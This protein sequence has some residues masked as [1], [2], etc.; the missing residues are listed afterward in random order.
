M[1]SIEEM[2][3]QALA[4]DRH[5]I[6]RLITIMESRGES[7]RACMAVLY[8][9]TGKAHVVGITG[10]PGTGK[11]S[12]VNE[13]ARAY[14]G[15]GK[16]V[17]VVAVDP[18][19]PFTGGAVLGD[20]LRMRDVATNPAVFIRSMASRGSLGGLA[21]ATLDAV[22]VLDACGYEVILV[23]TVGA[24]QNEVD[25]A[26]MADTT[27]VVV[28][29]SAG[30][31]I[32]TMK[33]GVLE[34]ADVLVVNKADLPGA[35]VAVMALEGM[36][37]MGASPQRGH[38]SMMAVAPGGTAPAAAQS[39]WKP[40]IIKTCAI[41]GE[42]VDGI[43]GAVARHSQFTEAVGEK[44]RRDRERAKFELESDL[45]HTL[46]TALLASLP[47]TAVQDAIIRIADRRVTPQNAARDLIA[48]A[49]SAQHSRDKG[50][51]PCGCC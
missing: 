35:D 4:G 3:H 6:A 30:D 20:R 1:A 48:L 47:E 25:V 32:Q 40:P 9:L 33:A 49:R 22:R 28:M 10:A 31:D 34:V 29:P 44:T 26:R 45:R 13:L 19:S 5:A 24:G 50:P 51:M 8:P 15:A 11:S 38:H 17:G 7:A 41:S 23:E 2:L 27:I 43:I 16:K 12:L 37:E 18:T 46:L 42:G 21:P 14:L 36:L 39:D